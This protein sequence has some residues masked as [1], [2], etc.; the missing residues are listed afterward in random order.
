MSKDN[1]KNT[2]S[3]DTSWQKAR[4]GAGAVAG[5]II[6]S[7]AAS[8]PVITSNRIHDSKIDKLRDRI[9]DNRWKGRW[10][11]ARPPARA[12]AERALRHT[13]GAKIDRALSM[14]AIPAVMGGLLVGGIGGHK[15]VKR[16]QQKAQEKTAGIG[17]VGAEELAE[18]ESMQR[19]KSTTGQ[20]LA[21]LFN[22]MPET[23]KKERAE[24][25][26]FF[27]QAK[28]GQTMAP[29]LQKTSSIAPRVTEFFEKKA[30]LE[31]A[32]RLFPEIMS[33][34]TASFGPVGNV[35]GSAGTTGR[36]TPNLKPRMM[37]TNKGPIPT[38]APSS[39]GSA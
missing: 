35:A 12:V 28:A 8:L 36:P 26:G 39:V 16:H 2:K 11:H 22:V 6:G 37:A 5:A 1:E 19:E 29:V 30:H 10:I 38:A 27:L 25:E 13:T 34:K 9:L 3:T 15:L 20:Q 24:M 31:T 23:K 7:S 32:E 33:V 17:N 14:T 21:A 4:R 18:L